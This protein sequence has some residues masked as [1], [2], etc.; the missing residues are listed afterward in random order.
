MIELLGRFLRWFIRLIGAPTLLRLVL[1]CLTM[2]CVEGGLI[3]I[4]GHIRPDWLA[5]TAVYGVLL[6]WLLGRS[7]LHGW[8]SGLAALGIGLLWLALSVGQMSLPLDALLL[9]LPSILKQVIF[10]LPLDLGPLQAAWALFAQDLAGLIGRLTLWIQNAGTRTIINDPGVTSLIW[11]LALW[12]VSF[13]AAWWLRRK[14]A[15]GVGLLPATV[16]LVYNVYYTNSAIGI[17]WVVFTGGGWILLQALDGYLKARRRWQ[18]RRMGRTEIEPLL[19]TVVFLLAAGLMLAGGLLPSVSIRKISDTLQRVFQSRQDKALAESL[20]LQQTPVLVP[21]GGSGYV[22]LSDTH[23]VG[24]GPQLSQE[25][26]LYVS[27][28]GYTPPPPPEVLIHNNAVPP[29]VRYYWRSQTF[30]F[31]NGH[32]W[33]ATPAQTQA[34]PADRP[35]F[36]NLVTL[37]QNYRLVR[38]HVQR[39]QPMKAAVFVTGDLLSADTP[40]TADWRASGDLIDAR[41]NANTYTADSRVQNVT[42]AQLRR[43]GTDYPAS[44]RSY[45]ALP[46]ELPERVRDLAV[47]LTIGQPSPYDQVMAIQDYLRQF[48]Y[49]LKVPGVP[50]NREVADYFLFDLQKGYCDYFAT[51]MAVMV[52]AVGIPAR[53]VTGFSSGTY[54]YKTNRFVVVEANAHSWVEVY[55]PRIGFVEFEPTTNQVPFQRPGETANPNKPAIS[56][57]P[58]VPLAKPGAAPINWAVLRRPL[59]VLEFILAGLLVLL[60]VGLLLPVESW[61]LTLRPAEKA[62]PAIQQRLYRQGRVWGVASDAARTP[63]EFAQALSLKLER[64]KANQRLAAVTVSLLA[65]LD[66][67]TALY[68]RLLFSQHPPSQAEHRQAV[69]NWARLRKSLRKIRNS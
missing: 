46:D 23:A 47:R 24:P 43:A 32:V 66:W 44:I 13:W 67:L 22:G 10:R 68:T 30:D 41:V 51:T 1:L 6:G 34:M 28:D 35:Y 20:G 52:R 31:Y 3:A 61:Y 40:S 49:T 26:M 8:G 69:Q 65:D 62:I 18:E 16:L 56:I 42:V 33:V 12:L 57:P 59:L 5:S 63:A 11:G 36:P 58:V 17:Y 29:E 4:V 21:G 53:L 39:L 64:F 48:P 9:T 15:L 60:L 38:Q 7:R 2:L 45:L 25:V 37:P 55:F 50:T 27:V 14:D 19:T 54:D